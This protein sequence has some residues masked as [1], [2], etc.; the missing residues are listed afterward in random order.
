MNPKSSSHHPHTAQRR[1]NLPIFNLQSIFKLRV[2]H[3][4]L[5]TPRGSQSTVELRT[6]EGS[7]SQLE[8]ES[9]TRG[10]DRGPALNS[11]DLSSL[12]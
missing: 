11:S 10:G 1:A 2:S 7:Q 8:P 5:R 12:W 6:P 4:A 3:F 9:P